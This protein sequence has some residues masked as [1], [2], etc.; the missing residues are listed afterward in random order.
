[1]FADLLGLFPAISS[2][3]TLEVWT[4]AESSKNTKTSYFGGSRSFN[5]VDVNTAKKL[6]TSACRDKQ[7]VYAYLQLFSH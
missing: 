2:Q 3:F 7:H 1:M 4:A 5:V 6:V